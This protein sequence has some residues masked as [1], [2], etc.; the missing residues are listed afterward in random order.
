M[1]SV[2]I[3]LYNKA[4]T[5]VKTL[6]TVFTQTYQNF[7]V[8][9]VDDGSTD[10]S[11]D[12][13]RKEFDDKRIHIIK[14]C[15]GG[16]SVARNTGIKK[17]KGEWIA[18]LDADDEWLPGYLSTLMEA[19]DNYPTIDLLL[20][21]RYR[22]NIITRERHS[23]VPTQ[24]VNKVKEINFFYNPHVFVHI[25]ATIVRTKL[26]KDN[27][28]TFGSFIEGQ[29]S[30]EDFTF[31]YRVALHSRCLYIGKPLAI[32]N[33]GVFGQATVIL[34]EQKKLVDNILM[35]NLVIDEW[36]ATGR[37]NNICGIFM[38]YETRHTIL[39][40]LKVHN[41]IGLQTLICGMNA[42]C[43]RF[44]FG[45]MERRVLMNPLF[46]KLSL[47]YLYMTKVV[48]RLHGFPVVR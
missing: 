12:I 13:I 25:S 7:E 3:P 23:V 45:Y 42:N 9:I 1:I 11:V 24:Y 22:Q 20:S 4:H 10:D 32:Y 38:K 48:W 21:G 35:R 30:N 2:V 37:K 6:R 34:H 39:G 8:I 17:S 40:L 36:C 33:E 5:I 16:V 44:Y 41:Y 47:M 43:R 29:A 15:N 31:L 46:H 18:F 14:Q 26:L 28:D 27:F 19:V